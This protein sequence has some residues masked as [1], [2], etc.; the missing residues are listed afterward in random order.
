[1]L[2]ENPM[3]ISSIY[4]HCPLY[5]DIVP[6]TCS[7]TMAEMK[8]NASDACPDWT[9]LVEGVRNKNG[10][11]IAE[12]YREFE[13][14]T[15]KYLYRVLGN[16]GLEQLNDSTAECMVLM[17]ESI[18]GGRIRLPE[19]LPGYLRAIARTMRPSDWRIG[20]A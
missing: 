19:S 7:G 11:A 13:K 16:R 15:L 8:R 20:A 18:Q 14:C 6:L 10:A 3:N 1:M 4:L 12:L 5:L 2:R 9:G 17:V